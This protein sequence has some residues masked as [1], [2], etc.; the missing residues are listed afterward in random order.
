MQK[1]TRK[2]WSLVR[3]RI[4]ECRNR[5]SNTIF[6]LL[7]NQGRYQGVLVVPHPQL[8]LVIPRWKGNK[9]FLGLFVMS[10]TFFCCSLSRQNQATC[11]AQM[12]ATLW[13]ITLLLQ[14]YS[15][16]SADFDSGLM[17]TSHDPPAIWFNFIITNVCKG[18]VA[19]E[20]VVTES[21]MVHILSASTCASRSVLLLCFVLLYEANNQFL[22]NQLV[23]TD[24][25]TNF[26]KPNIRYSQ[27]KILAILA[28]VR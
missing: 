10:P 1:H 23:E 5:F 2:N 16:S 21:E 17:N 15:I 4:K 20:K 24:S 19:V 9:L 14:D 22:E 13:N 25:E 8:R 27:E 11:L 18:C 26:Y 7:L 12:F 28:F 6:C 3:S